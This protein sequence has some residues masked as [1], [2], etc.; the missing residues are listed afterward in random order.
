MSALDL[1]APLDLPTAEFSPCRT[2]RYVLRRR[3]S[4]EPAIAFVLLNPSTADET[5]DDPTIRRCI[6]YARAW[7]Y[8]ALTLGNL[9][10]FRATKPKNMRAAPDPV[11]PANDDALLALTLESDG[12]VICG[13][14]AHGAHQGRSAEVY[15]LLRQWA[16]VP[17]ALAVTAAGEPGHPLYLRGDLKPAPWAPRGEA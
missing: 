11:G 7:G 9:F 13:W 8:G 4:S 10:A 3:W 1:R 12:R 6:G 17:Q 2:W 15:R 14:G 16:V 5:E